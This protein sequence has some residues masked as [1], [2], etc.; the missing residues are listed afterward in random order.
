VVGGP[1]LPPRAACF[2]V[3]AALATGCALVADV[4]VV[5]DGLRRPALLAMAGI[6]S[7]RSALG[8]VGMTALLSPGSDSAQFRR[9]DR[10]LYALLCL[11]L[12]LGSLAARR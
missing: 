12:A 9:L 4:P 6:L 7:L 11:G 1:D 10:R 5:P 2:A 8:F 3:A